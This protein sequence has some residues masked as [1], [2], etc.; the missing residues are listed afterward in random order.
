MTAV[1]RVYVNERAID[2]PAGASAGAAVAAHN[3]D[4]GAAVAQ[5]RA[6]LTDGRGI[7]LAADAT[8]ADGAIVR[9]VRPASQR[10]TGGSDG[11]AQP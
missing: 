6:Y 1:I 10:S 9:V 8:L 7:R 11:D 4:L 3:R 2:L 5:G